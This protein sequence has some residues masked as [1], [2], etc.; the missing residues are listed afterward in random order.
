[1]WNAGGIYGRR[2]F[3]FTAQL[4]QPSHSHGTEAAAHFATAS[5]QSLVVFCFFAPFIYFCFIFNNQSDTKT[6]R[7]PLVVVSSAVSGFLK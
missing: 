5:S 4:P 1:M 3:T 6:N 2:E 7:Q